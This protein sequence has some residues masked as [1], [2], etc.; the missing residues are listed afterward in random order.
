MKLLDTE[1]LADG[2]I[3]RDW[4]HTGDSG[5][6]VITTEIEQDVEPILEQAKRLYNDAPRR[7]GDGL[8]HRV[9]EIPFTVAEEACRI[10]KIP[11]LD[12]WHRRTAE[13]ARLWDDLL[14]GRDFR[15]FRTRP[16]QV[17]IRRR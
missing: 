3:Q 16:G 10:R 4:L 1:K 6:N 14:N 13:A 5:R 2:R 9:A 8:M 12:F 7:F 17:K 15:A 11:W